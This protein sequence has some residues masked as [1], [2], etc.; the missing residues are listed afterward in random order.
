MANRDQTAAQRESVKHD[1]A[2]R[3]LDPTPHLDGRLDDHGPEVTHGHVHVRGGGNDYDHH[4]PGGPDHNHDRDRPD[5]DHPLKF[6]RGADD[7]D[8]S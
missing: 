7:N 2:H 5:T 8:S 4:L 1:H 3:H 6:D